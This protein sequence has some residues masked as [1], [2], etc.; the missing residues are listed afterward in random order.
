[1]KRLVFLLLPLLAVDGWSQGTVA[2]NTATVLAPHEPMELEQLPEWLIE[3]VQGPTF[4]WYFAPS[5]SHCQAA[6]PGVVQLHEDIGEEVAFLGIASSRSTPEEMDVFRRDYAVPFELRVDDSPGFAFAVGARSTPTA[7]ML[8]RREGEVLSLDGYYP[9]RPGYELIVKMR[10]HPEQAFSTFEPDVYQGPTACAA[11][12]SQEAE[13]WQLTHHAVAYRTLYKQ[14]RTEDSECVGCHV[15]GLGE[16]G[17]FVL[18]DHGDTLQDVTCEACHSAGGP[19]DGKS[20]DAREQCVRCHDAEHSIAFNVDKGMPWIDHFMANTMSPGERDKR[21]QELAQGEAERPLLA[22]P[23]GEH[24][25]SEACQDCHAEQHA[26]WKGSAHG[27][28]MDSLDRKER[29][30]PRC[31]RCHATPKTSG[32][33]PKKVDE[34]LDAVECESCHGPGEQHAA[35]PTSSNILGLGESCPECVIEAV[36]TTCHD[37][38]NDPQW[39]L[40]TRL[41]AVKH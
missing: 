10:L 16:D 20:V 5:C 7:L 31:V 1:M 33:P 22:F 26:S 13:S 29:R 12:H 8:D 19:H 28:A 24:V 2:A 37:R 32:L 3:K 18:G 23:E 36:C 9:W 30:N 11:C 6:I 17:G 4:V 38:D 15:T 34:Y 40:H 21:W 39:D 35:E 41:D 14:D 25:G 27:G